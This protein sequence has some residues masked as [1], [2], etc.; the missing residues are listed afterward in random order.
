MYCFKALDSSVV[1]LSGNLAKV[2]CISFHAA[3]PSSALSN[4]LISSN[5]V[6]LDINLLGSLISQLLCNRLARL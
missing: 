2:V 1:G 6:E 3:L 4:A 5:M